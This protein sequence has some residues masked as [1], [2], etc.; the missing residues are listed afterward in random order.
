MGVIPILI[1]FGAS[2]RVVLVRRRPNT[3]T[4]CLARLDERQPPSSEGGMRDFLS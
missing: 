2:Y 3:Q 1:G 4:R